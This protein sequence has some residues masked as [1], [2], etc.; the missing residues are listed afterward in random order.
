MYANKFNT[1]GKVIQRKAWLVAKGYSQV[2]GEDFEETYAAVVHLESLR[3]S[4]AI[5]AQ[6][7][8][9]IWQVD[10]V[11]AY[12]NSIP[13]HE[14]YMCL[15]PG[16]L[17]GEGKLAL[18]QKT[19]Y[20]LMQSGFNWYWTLDGAFSDLG[21]QRS[22]ADLCV[23]SKK[24][25]QEVTITNTFNDNTFGLS[26]S[27]EGARVAKQELAQVYKVKDLGEPTFILEMAIP[28]DAS[29]RSISLSQKA[30]LTQVLEQF[31][32]T[33]CNS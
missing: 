12:L 32:M 17:G 28:H 26:M 30:Y 31:K 19:L 20:G 7:G 22:R 23:H 13:E 2:V 33:D 5:A 3:M 21:Y 4:V 29:T 14:M 15:P 16:F 8:L 9:E 1:E 11:S 27:K 25:G 24:V 10:F 18:L 6:E